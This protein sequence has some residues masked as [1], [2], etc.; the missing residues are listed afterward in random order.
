MARFTVT[1]VY[2]IS[3]SLRRRFVSLVWKVKAKLLYV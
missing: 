1:R 2:K 3:G